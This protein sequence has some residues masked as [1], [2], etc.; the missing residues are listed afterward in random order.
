MIISLQIIVC[1]R[2][3]LLFLFLD[4]K[5]RAK[6]QSVSLENLMKKEAEQRQAIKKGN[7]SYFAP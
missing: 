7:E 5:L 3:K 6:L 1:F 2:F 4:P